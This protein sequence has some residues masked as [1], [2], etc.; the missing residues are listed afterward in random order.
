MNKIYDGYIL[1][2]TATVNTKVRDVVVFEESIGIAQTEGKSGELISVDTVGVYE[3]PSDTTE[4]VKVG[5]VLY[6]D[7]DNSVVTIDATDNTK[8]GVAWSPKTAGV[9]SM[10]LVKIG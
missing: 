10:L 3:F 1:T 2:M 6:W 8:C 5:D 4:T 7:A 9:E